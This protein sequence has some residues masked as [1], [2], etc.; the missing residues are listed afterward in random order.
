MEKWEEG[1]Q[2]EGRNQSFLVD[3]QV[4][5]LILAELAK[6]RA[7]QPEDKW[8]RSPWFRLGRVSPARLERS[9]ERALLSAQSQVRPKTDDGCS[10]GM[11]QQR[12]RAAGSRATSSVTQQSFLNINEVKAGTSPEAYLNYEK[13]GQTQPTLS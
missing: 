2:G 11:Q 5:L 7:A 9:R 1:C 13:T 4:V 12:A 8:I 10:S 6:T 3:N